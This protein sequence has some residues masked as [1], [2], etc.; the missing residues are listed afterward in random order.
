MKRTLAT[1]ALAAAL[2]TTGATTASAYAPPEKPTA[3]AGYYIPVSPVWTCIAALKWAHAHG[4]KEDYADQAIVVCSQRVKTDRQA[5][6]LYA[7]ANRKANMWA[8]EYI[9]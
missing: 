1:V 6:R 4:D 9:G 7:W 3:V 5:A 8:L 2:I